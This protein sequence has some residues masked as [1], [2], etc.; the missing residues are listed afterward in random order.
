MQWR[1]LRNS[2]Y[3]VAGA[4]G[5]GSHVLDQLVRLGVRRLEVWDPGVLDEPDLNRQALYT[6]TDLGRH[7]VEA[8]AERLLSIHPDISLHV[9]TEPVLEDSPLGAKL[10]GVDVCF[11]CLDTAG[12]RRG[13]EA[14]LVAAWAGGSA[15]ADGPRLFV[16]GGVSGY[17]GQVVVFRPPAFALKH[18]FGERTP[19][20]TNG[21]PPVLES[22]VAMVA[23]TQV[24][25]HLR[26][27]DEPTPPPRLITID[28]RDMRHDV[29]DLRMPEE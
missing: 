11:D 20:V 29:V 19:A 16:H 28:A 26:M 6:R 5:L 23:S 22:A 1:R 7:K 27:L 4:G 18:V 13:L 2:R 10:G 3:V 8:A 9:L 15:T 17:S 21:P 24:A 12:A 25:E 14:A